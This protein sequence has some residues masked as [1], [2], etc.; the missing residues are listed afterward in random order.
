MII[1]TLKKTKISIVNYILK[2]P[3]AKQETT[4][5]ALSIENKAYSL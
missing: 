1:N 5:K 3:V 2:A 4:L